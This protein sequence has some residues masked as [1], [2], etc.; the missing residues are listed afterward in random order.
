MVRRFL[1]ALAALVLLLAAAV[2][3]NTWRH[4]SR[5]LDVPAAPPLALDEKAVADKLAALVRLR[6]V[7]L[8]DD[9][10]ANADQ[11]RQLHAELARRFPLVHA[12]LQREEVGGFGL[13]YTWRGTEAGA[14][15]VALMA[16]H[17]VVP[18]AP[19]TE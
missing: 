6:T 8:P 16:H 5:Q 19:G 12:H 17:D 15:P 4:G 1:L 14:K 3:L 7:S 2:A 13:L 10:Q 11:F 9:P 18:V